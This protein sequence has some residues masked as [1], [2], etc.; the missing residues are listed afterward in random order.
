MAHSEMG[1]NP[2]YSKTHTIPTHSYI[3]VIPQGRILVISIEI[4]LLPIVLVLRV[5]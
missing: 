5:V 1:K 2:R 4:L 3:Q